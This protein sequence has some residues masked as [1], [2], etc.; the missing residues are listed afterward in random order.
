M[1]SFFLQCSKWLLA[2]PFHGLEHAGGFQND[3]VGS[4]GTTCT[5]SKKKGHTDGNSFV[6]VAKL[7]SAN[8]FFFF[9]PK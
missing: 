6:R 8:I 4:I 9:F 1:L 7:S 2:C 5:F 3:T